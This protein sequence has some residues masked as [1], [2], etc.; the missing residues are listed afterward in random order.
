MTEKTLEPGKTTSIPFDMV[1]ECLAITPS[2]ADKKNTKG[3]AIADII[4]EQQIEIELP[5]MFCKLAVSFHKKY[6]VIRICPILKIKNCLPIKLTFEVTNKEIGET[7]KQVGSLLCQETAQI[8][9]LSLQDSFFLRVGLAG[10]SASAKIQL[11]SRKE[12]MLVNKISLKGSTGSVDLRVYRPPD[13]NYEIIIYAKSCI[14]N[15]TS[16]PLLYFLKDYKPF[17]GSS[18][19][20]AKGTLVFDKIKEIRI[21]PMMIGGD[22]T[23]EI[24]IEGLGDRSVDMRMGK[25]PSRRFNLGLNISS[26]L[27]DRKYNL[28]TKVVSVAP[29]F[30]VLNETPYSL[31]VIQDRA[32]ALD[33]TMESNERLI[34]HFQE[35]QLRKFL[36]FK[37]KTGNDGVK[38]LWAGAI[39]CTGPGEY[40]LIML[41]SQYQRAKYFRVSITLESP[42]YYIQIFEQ[43]SDK[44]AM[45]IVNDLD[46]LDLTVAQVGMPDKVIT[47]PRK[48]RVSFGWFEPCDCKNVLVVRLLDGLGGNPV[49]VNNY[50]F[51][52]IGEKIPILTN[53]KHQDKVFDIFMEINLEGSSKVMRFITQSSKASAKTWDFQASLTIHTIGCSVIYS[54]GK[55]RV[56]MVYM[57]L[58]PVA[59]AIKSDKRKLESQ[60]KIKV[61]EID[62]NT[63]YNT[64]YPC[65]LYP[66]NFAKENRDT[67]VLDILTVFYVPTQE[68]QVITRLKCSNLMFC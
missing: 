22:F 55:E 21:Q 2:H 19:Q 48:K 59:M 52:K 20:N 27:C 41:D 16:I 31:I 36:R 18:D 29:R 38:W 54:R 35:P 14:V 66:V 56:E 60:I 23:E 65:V 63:V 53:Y 47:I 43:L 44:T 1:S 24:P 67:Y 61:I 34:M 13:D 45:R 17:P 42:S 28:M 49:Y 46:C 6:A 9:A 4:K 40:Y 3:Y 58:H 62:N 64:L 7:R 50:T 68:N 57:A 32:E 10:Y 30:V 11:S 8:N 5:T 26:Q 37:I 12:V 39:D 25:S 33:S 51:D 15:E